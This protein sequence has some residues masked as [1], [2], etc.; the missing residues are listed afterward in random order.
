MRKGS[1]R[2]YNFFFRDSP[3]H[4]RHV[5][6]LCPPF[7]QTRRQQILIP[8][9]T[10]LFFAASTP[11]GKLVEVADPRA[12]GRSDGQQRPRTAPPSDGE[13]EEMVMHE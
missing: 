12:S 2:I 13:E 6:D 1:I 4:I 11:Q 10:L 3:A 9:P 8:Y 5:L 7:V